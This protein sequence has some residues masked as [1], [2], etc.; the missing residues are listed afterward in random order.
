MGVNYSPKIVTSGLILNVDAGNS[1]SYSGSGTSIYDLSG[2]NHTGTLTNSPTYSNNL[3][4]FVNTSSQYIDFG[5]LN[6]FSFTN[7]IFTMSFWV[8]FNSTGVQGVL[9]KRGNPWEYS[10]FVNPSGTLNFVCWTSGGD[11]VYVTSTTFSSNTWYNFCWTANGSNAFLYK[12]ASLETI[13][14]KSGFSMSNTVQPLSFGAGGNA[15]TGLVYLNGSMSSFSLYNKHLLG[16]E[17]QQNFNSLR[18]RF[19]I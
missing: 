8:K 11:G 5:D 2:Y 13:V 14:A 17:V 6:T 10:V 1:K 16:N 3:L 12:N 4:N 19:G 9:G 7:N 18:G 15:A